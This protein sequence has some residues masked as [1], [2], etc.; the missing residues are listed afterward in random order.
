MKT[1]HLDD[2][3]KGWFVGD[4]EPSSLQTPAAEVAV[5]KYVAGDREESHIHKIATELTLILSGRAEMNGRHYSAG[6][7]VLVEPGE[8]TDFHAVTDCVNVVV[9]V[10]S[11]RNDKY[12]AR[13][14]GSNA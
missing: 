2:M 7:I 10:P 6:D 9:K 4:F 13:S 12:P 8:A 5:K 11:S 3:V 14:A 1:S